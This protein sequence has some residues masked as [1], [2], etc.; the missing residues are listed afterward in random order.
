MGGLAEPDASQ[1]QEPIELAIRIAELI[2]GTPKR[3]DLIVAQDA[4]PGLLGTD[5]TLGLDR[6][7]G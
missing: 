6:G 4:L 7:G 5:E 3:S 1:K 2:R